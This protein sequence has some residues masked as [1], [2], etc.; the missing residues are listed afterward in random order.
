MPI[1]SFEVSYIDQSF[2]SQ[3]GTMN[4]RQRPTELA[5]PEL[6]SPHDADEHQPSRLGFDLRTF[7][8]D[9]RHH[10]EKL[11][12]ETNAKRRHSI[13]LAAERSKL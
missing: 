2:W 9:E 8:C 3:Q 7:K 1:K 10:I 6:P 12:V 11:A 4:E 13:G 5:A